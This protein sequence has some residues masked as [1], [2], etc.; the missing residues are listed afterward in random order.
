MAHDCSI[1]KVHVLGDGKVMSVSE[2]SIIVW[3]FESS[4]LLKSYEI[5]SNVDGLTSNST[6]LGAYDESYRRS[7]RRLSYVGAASKSGLDYVLYT[8]SGH[9][10]LST[11]IPT[12]GCSDERRFFKE[13]D[14]IKCHPTERGEDPSELKCSSQYVYDEKGNKLGKSKLSITSGAMLPLRRVLLLGTE[15]GL[16]RAII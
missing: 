8:F 7:D 11:P 16:I 10:V 2:R 6:I 12:A 13:G 5:K 3:S 9:K 15:D 4:T 1:L 14:V